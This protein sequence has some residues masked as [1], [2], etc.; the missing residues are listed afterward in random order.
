MSEFT[1]D[2]SFV[3][4]AEESYS[5]SKTADGVLRFEV[6]GGDFYDNPLA[7]PELDD[8]AQGKNRSELTSLKHMQ[9]ERKFTLEYDFLIESGAQNTAAWMLLTQ[10][11]QY[12]DINPDGSLKDSG[13]ASPPF[14]V[15]MRGE[16]MEISARTDPNAVTQATPP[17]L[18]QPGYDGAGVET[19]YL[20]TNPVARDTWINLK[21]EIVFDWD[22][23]GAGMLKVTRDGVVL[24]D[25]EGPI[26]YNDQIGPYLQMGVYREAV[27]E[28]FAVQFR[29]VQ[30]FG[31]GTPPPING[32]AGDD[33][34]QATLIGFFE[35]E[36]LNGYAGNDTLNGGVGADTMNGGA[37]N[38]EYIVENLGDVVN[39][40]SGGVDQG[41][42]DI[43]KST[44]TWTLNADIEDLRLQGT[45]NI[46]G[47][48][49]AKANVLQGNDA[50][51]I[52]YGL[53]GND[54]IQAAD[55]A[56][57]V[58]AGDGNDT[59]AGGLGNDTVY[60]NAGNDEIYGN[61][62]NDTLYGGDGQD[63]LYGG[64]G[65]DVMDGGTGDDVYEVDNVGDVVSEGVDLS[66][67]H[68]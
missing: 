32:T 9:F 10:F 1:D 47:T 59:A 6:R 51:N 21:I 22:P 28:T 46:N 11:H 20:D 57:N 27:D 61:E 54:S 44:V 43:V 50:N 15:Q 30:Y 17:R 5:Y 36:E 66:L 56:D 13:L 62:G 64:T 53:G 31:D 41:G 26:G 23:A 58:I 63:T 65:A 2:N 8:E 16:R 18:T 24:V 34:I 60:G 35:D 14:A 68:I 33:D 12:E 42:H 3:K 49:N 38:D 55:G 40:R 29:N 4:N 25:Y 37:G 67:I 19:M 52:I 45:E 48:G 39:E 7:P